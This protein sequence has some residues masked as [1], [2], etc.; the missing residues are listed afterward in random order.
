MVLFADY[1][2]FI[3]CY[4]IKKLGHSTNIIILPTST[5]IPLVV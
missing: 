3:E 4:S 1:Y 5:N 2:A